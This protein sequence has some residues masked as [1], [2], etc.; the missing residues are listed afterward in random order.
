MAN[1]HSIL[2]VTM[3]L[4]SK[5]EGMQQLVGWDRERERKVIVQEVLRPGQADTAARAISWALAG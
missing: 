2:F 5:L 1:P 4:E 3:R